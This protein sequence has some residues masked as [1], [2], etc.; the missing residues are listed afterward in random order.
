MKFVL[1]WTIRDV[2]FP[3]SIRDAQPPIF[4]SLT[5]YFYTWIP[6]TYVHIAPG[7]TK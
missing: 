7:L 3:R 5:R 6:E 1:K 4:S 2:Q